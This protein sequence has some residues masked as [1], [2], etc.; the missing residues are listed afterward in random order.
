[1]R[2]TYSNESKETRDGKIQKPFI[3]E[4]EMQIEVTSNNSTSVNHM[5]TQFAERNHHNSY[6]LI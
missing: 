1:M 6:F 5:S 2:N 4:S 3:C